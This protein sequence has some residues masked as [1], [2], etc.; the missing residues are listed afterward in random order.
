VLLSY[1]FSGRRVSET[2]TQELLRGI[3]LGDFD[4]DSVHF[5]ESLDFAITQLHGEYL[6][7]R[8]LASLNKMKT[9]KV[10]G[11]YA[12]FALNSK[13]G[14][15]PYSKIVSLHNQSGV[16]KIGERLMEQA[17][18]NGGKY[19]ECFGSYIRTFYSLNFEVYKTVDGIQGHPETLYFMKMKGTPTPF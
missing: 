4:N 11:S 1:A 6:S 19:L 16:K 10:K 18:K 15:P 7:K 17:I 3:F 8:S 2:D 12:G 13:K 5:K 9:F 14:M